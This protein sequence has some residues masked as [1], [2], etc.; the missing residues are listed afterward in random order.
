[1]LPGKTVCRNTALVLALLWF[2]MW[3]WCDVG[4]TLVCAV[5]RLLVKIPSKCYFKR[6]ALTAKLHCDENYKNTMQ[7]ELSIGS[8]IRGNER[9]DC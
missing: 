6:E 5:V 9:Y 8:V 1:M 7:G 3:Q 4:Q 2:G